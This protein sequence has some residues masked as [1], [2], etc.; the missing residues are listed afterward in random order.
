MREQYRCEDRRLDDV[1][2]IKRGNHFMSTHKALQS[3]LR[4]RCPESTF[5]LPIWCIGAGSREHGAWSKLEANRHVDERED[6]LPGGLVV[7]LLVCWS[8]GL[9]RSGRGQHSIVH[10]PKSLARQRETQEIQQR[11]CSVF[12][13]L[14]ATD[15]R[16]DW[17]DGEY[18]VPTFRKQGPLVSMVLLSQRAKSPRQLQASMP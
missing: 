3:R 10:S 17:V 8:V 13:D 9:V 1:R 11:V 2:N 6:C 5:P 18:K 4:S 15:G 16:P 14:P 7:H 12:R